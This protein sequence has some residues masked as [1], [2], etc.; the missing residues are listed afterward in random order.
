MLQAEA[1]LN[2]GRAPEA[3]PLI[4]VT[5]TANGLPAIPTTSAATDAVPGGTACVPRMP[6]PGVFTTSV[7]GTVFEA[8]KWEKRLETA[9]T[10]YAQWYLDSRGWGDLPVGTGTSWPVPYQEL[11]SRGKPLYNGV[12]V[13]GASTYGLGRGGNF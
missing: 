1:L 3:I 5:R 10:G 4:N 13:A 12:T 11:D 6:Q 9:L 2:L 8:M 7:C